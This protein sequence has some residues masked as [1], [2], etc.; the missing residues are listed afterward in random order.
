MKNLLITL[1]DSWTKGVGAYPPFVFEKYQGDV[2]QTTKDEL[3][4]LMKYY[5]ENSWAN[6]LSIKLNYELLNLSEAGSS[7][8]QMA[9]IF[10]SLDLTQKYNKVLVIFL[11]TDPHRLSFYSNKIPRTLAHNF[12]LTRGDTAIFKSY[13]S[14]III[15]KDDPWLETCFYVKAIENLCKVNNYCFCFGSAFSDI[16]PL[17]KYYHAP[18]LLHGENI[19]CYK[20]ILNN[21]DIAPCLHPNK[22]G[23]IKIAN[24]MYDILVDKKIIGD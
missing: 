9:K 6:L 7:N 3:S 20:D 1:G 8:S 24:V 16:T 11:L 22:N 19:T 15:D 14:D 10:Y 13:L 21:N 5:M 18:N 2:Y 23:Y 17:L 12:E 4:I